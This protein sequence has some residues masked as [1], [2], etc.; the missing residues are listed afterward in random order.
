MKAAN[1]MSVSRI[2]GPSLRCI[3]SFIRLRGIGHE[4]QLAV[5]SPSLDRPFV[6]RTNKAVIARV[7]LDAH[8]K[9]GFVYKAL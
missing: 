2:A 5:A 4:Y 9:L 6:I 3:S 8:G 1:Q 7:E